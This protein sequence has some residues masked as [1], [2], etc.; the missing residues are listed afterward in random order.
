MLLCPAGK[1]TVYHTLQ[2]PDS[3]TNPESQS[4]LRNLSYEIEITR[5]RL[6]VLRSE[7]RRDKS[8]LVA[9]EAKPTI[10]E[11]RC[12][13]EKLE[14]EKEDI[15]KYLSLANPVGLDEAGTGTEAGEEEVELSAE[16]R[17][18]LENE[19]NKARKQMELR[20]KICRELWGIC[21][22]VLPGNM[23]REEIWVSS[24]FFQNKQL[25]TL[26]SQRGG[27]LVLV[28]LV[29]VVVLVANT[30]IGIIRP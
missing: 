4:N 21:T 6:A 14:R 20:K 29:L 26:P 1:Q 17:S 10:S 16:E 28:V 22:E 5:D 2:N 15:E 25:T 30:I 3:E 13:I 23:T 12:S 24:D 7:E 18:D 27:V 9:L 8:A 11:L 19:W